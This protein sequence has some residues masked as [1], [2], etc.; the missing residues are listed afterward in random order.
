MN[1]KKNRTLQPALILFFI[2]LAA[3]LPAQTTGVSGDSTINQCETKTYIISVLNNSGSPLTAM[4]VTAKLGNLT[5]F[6]YVSGTASIDVNGGA[7][8]CTANPTPSGD[9]II[10]NIDADCGGSFTL[11]N[12]ETLNVTFDL[13]TDCAAVSGS[14]NVRVDYEIGGTPTFDETGALSIQVLPGG[15][16]IKKTPNVIPQEIGQDVTWTLTVENTGFGT[17]QNVVVSD[18]LAPDWHMVLPPRPA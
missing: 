3:A 4:V 2:L 8:F 7:S 16:T 14:L 9:D 1:A 5:G 17:I 6:S 18:V 12:G 11:A 10:W 13:A 15:V